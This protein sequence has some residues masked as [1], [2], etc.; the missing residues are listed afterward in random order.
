VWEVLLAVV[1]LALLVTGEK[2]LADVMP[3]LCGGFA[4]FLTKLMW[5][6]RNIL[7]FYHGL[8]PSYPQR[9]NDNLG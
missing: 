7:D 8:S 4:I 3:S 9:I 6:V 5:I 1:V 2:W